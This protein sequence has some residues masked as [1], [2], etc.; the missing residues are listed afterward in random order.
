MRHASTAVAISTALLLVATEYVASSPPPTRKEDPKREVPARKD[1]SPPAERGL[2][3][4]AKAPAIVVTEKDQGKRI[5][6]KPGDII[7]VRLPV[8]T[9]FT[10]TWPSSLDGIRPLPDYPKEV[11]PPGRGKTQTLGGPMLW[12]GRFEVTGKPDAPI[13][14]SLIYCLFNHKE[15]MSQPSAKGKIV[16]PEAWANLNNQP[17]QEG[18]M[19]QVALDVKR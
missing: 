18:A 14:L 1:A 3:K 8:T 17:L 10:W 2:P 7:E 5:T 9:P 12:V 6:L 19:Y 16:P 13:L 15:I 11:F 4:D